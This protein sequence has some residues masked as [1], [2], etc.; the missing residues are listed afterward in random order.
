[1][2]ASDSIARDIS[3]FES[4]AQALSDVDETFGA[5]DKLAKVLASL[6]INY[7]SFV[8]ASDSYDETKQSFF[9]I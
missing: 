2:S 7:G 4:L 5:T 8:T 9:T 3:K 1:M 6:P